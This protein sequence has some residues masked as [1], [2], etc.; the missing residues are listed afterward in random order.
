MIALFK[1]NT[2]AGSTI[3]ETKGSNFKSTSILTPF[4]KALLI[5]STA[6]P[7]KYKDII[8][9]IIPKI[10]AEKLLISISNPVGIFGLIILSNFFIKKAP[11]GPVIIAPKNIGIFEPTIT[12]AAIIE[13]TTPPLCP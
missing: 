12:P 1:K 5:I 11:K 8:A 10:P 13:P 3:I 7:I 4:D 9:K 2:L 6:G